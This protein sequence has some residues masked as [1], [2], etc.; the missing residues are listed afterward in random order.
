MGEKL[1]MHHNFGT[2]C[3]RTECFHVDFAYAWLQVKRLGVGRKQEIVFFS[4]SLMEG[5]DKRWEG[6]K[7]QFFY[8]VYSFLLNIADAA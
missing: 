4:N 6:S 7:L 1:H 5:V 3:K 8:S 2:M